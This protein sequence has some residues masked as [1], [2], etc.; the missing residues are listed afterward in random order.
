MLL[1]PLSDMSANRVSVK[2]PGSTIAINDD[3]FLHS[4]VE[5]PCFILFLILR[6][7]GE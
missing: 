4:C 2:S 5:F 1:S 7:G 6:N 3:D